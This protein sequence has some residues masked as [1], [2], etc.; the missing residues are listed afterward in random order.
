MAQAQIT[1]NLPVLRKGQD[2]GD[3]AIERLQQ[4]LNETGFASLDTDAEFGPK[5]DTAVREFQR[6][7]RL[8]VDG[9]VG[10]QTWTRLLMYWFG[11]TS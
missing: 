11:L 6:S 9:I 5:T 3:T 8:A 7:E 1:L 2:K 4:L 10:K